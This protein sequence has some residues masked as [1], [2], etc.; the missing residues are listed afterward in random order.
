MRSVRQSF[1]GCYC[2][3]SL[4]EALDAAVA[5][6]GVTRSLWLRKALLEEL[7]RSGVKLPAKIIEPPSRL[8]KGGPKPKKPEGR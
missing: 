6:S 2:D 3:Q 5:R 4:I 7:N 8:G 1:V